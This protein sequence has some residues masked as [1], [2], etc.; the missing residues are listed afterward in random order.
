MPYIEE[1]LIINLGDM[2][3][4][5][6]NY[7]WKS[8]LHRVIIS[9]SSYSS[10]NEMISITNDN[11]NNNDEVVDENKNNEDCIDDV[12]I[13][14]SHIPRRQSIAFYLN[15]NPDSLIDIS[16]PS[17]IIQSAIRDNNYESDFISANQHLI[18]DDEL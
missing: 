12:C 15:I 9:S 18:Q 16:I 4:Q 5:W 8:T 3:K 1:G 11:D 10:E 2:M 14:R 13:T 6:T 7:Y 17:D